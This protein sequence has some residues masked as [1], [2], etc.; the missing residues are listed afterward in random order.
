M[1]VVV[2]MGLRHDPDLSG[3]QMN[4]QSNERAL[5][6]CE[7]QQGDGGGSGE[8]PADRQTDR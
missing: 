2:G 8:T 7:P 1:T 4:G 5:L 3:L 6:C